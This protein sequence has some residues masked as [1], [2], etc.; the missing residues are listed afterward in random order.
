[1]GG[2]VDRWMSEKTVGWMGEWT[3]GWTDGQVA[4]NVDGL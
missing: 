1:M 2:C 4:G 3:G